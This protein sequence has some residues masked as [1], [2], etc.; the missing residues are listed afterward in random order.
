MS[1]GPAVRVL[2]AED[3]PTVRDALRAL[4]AAEPGLEPVGTAGDAREAIRLAEAERPDVAL[5][6]VRMPEG[7]GQRA[8]RG[9]SKRSPETKVLALSA[10]ESRDTVLE[11]LEA[12]VVGYLVKGDSIDR[13]LESIQS[14]ANG[15]ASLS[16]EVTGEVIEALVEQRSLHRDEEERRREH[17][18]RI[19]RALQNGRA[20]TMA[21]QPIY[22]L[23]DGRIMGAEALA[24]FRERPERGPEEWFAEADEV[25]LRTE[26]ELTAVRMALDRLPRLPPSA[27]LGINASPSTA[28][29]PAFQQLLAPVDAGRVVIEITEHAPVDDYDELNAALCPLRDLGVRLA[30]DDAGAGFAS[31]R[32]IL[33]LAPDTIKLDRSL[34]D[35]IATDRSKQALA[36]GLISFAEKSDAAIVA[37][38]IELEQELEA[39][40]G[41]GVG[42]GQGFLLAPPGPLP[43]PEL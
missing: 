32:H 30:I 17:S 18:R 39:L 29:T 24:R 42:Y 12:G 6:D 13:I 20:L 21:F 10:D 36:A 1:A 4:I 43:L 23:D 11:M 9:I 8:A 40:R 22:G 35:G 34:I 19:V 15:Q 28:A 3:D 31:L 27:Y 25:G 14:A 5:V 16:I 33:R 26:L 38:G 2:I 7:G 37:E 41:L